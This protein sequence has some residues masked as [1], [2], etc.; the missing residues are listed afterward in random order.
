MRGWRWSNSEG[1]LN[2]DC[3]LEST[4][5]LHFEAPYVP[6]MYQREVTIVVT[7]SQKYQATTFSKVLD[8]SGLTT[9]ENRAARDLFSSV[10]ERIV[11]P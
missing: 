2:L 6:S 9:V 5:T 3:R 8:F 4:T 10:D 1:H 11:L 7:H